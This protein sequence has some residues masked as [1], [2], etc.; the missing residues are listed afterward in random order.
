MAPTAYVFINTESGK[1]GG[2][3][4]KDI[5]T[6]DGVK[7]AYLVYG[8]YDIVAKINVGSMDKLKEVKNDI[9][10]KEYVKSTLTMVAVEGFKKS[11]KR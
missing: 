9:R 4:A 11:N 8:V 5:K 6:I 2:E 3:A 1:D 7:E 10:S